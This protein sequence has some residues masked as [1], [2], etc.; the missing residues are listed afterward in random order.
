[1]ALPVVALQVIL[2]SLLSSALFEAIL[3]LLFYRDSA[4]MRQLEQL[5]RAGKRLEAAQEDLALDPN[6]PAKKKVQQ[7]LDKEVKGYLAAMYGT[8]IK[9]GLLTGASMIGG[10]WLIMRRFKGAVVAKMPFVP[11]GF[12][13]N[14][15]H[16]GLPGDD[17]TDVSAAFFYAVA[18]PWFRSNIVKAAGTGPSRAVAKLINGAPSALVD[19]KP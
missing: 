6:N 15:T 1:M 4:Y 16:M 8:K 17:L 18:T 13:S 7:R 5:E 19:K 14:L 9:I 2:L 11:P 10:M 3:W 12:F